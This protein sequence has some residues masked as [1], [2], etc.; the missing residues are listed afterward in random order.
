M[1]NNRQVPWHHSAR[2]PDSDNDSDQDNEDNGFDSDEDFIPLPPARNNEVLERWEH[3]E[4]QRQWEQD[5][6]ITPWEQTEEDQ[7]ERARRMM[8]EFRGSGWR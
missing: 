8:R 4:R 1:N 6:V 2:R 7:E 5:N 3:E